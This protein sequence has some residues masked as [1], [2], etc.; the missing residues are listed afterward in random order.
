MD[1]VML[2]LSKF[3]TRELG[4]AVKLL[5]LYASRKLS[6]FA[7]KNFYQEGVSLNFNTKSGNV[8][9][10]NEDYQV[11]VENNGELEMLLYCPNCGNE[12]TPNEFLDVNVAND[13]CQ[14][15]YHSFE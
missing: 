10:T 11:L 13:C 5:N 3:G 6:E 2:D 1:V 7:N 12:G 14:S 15:Y 9:L 8:F 4:F